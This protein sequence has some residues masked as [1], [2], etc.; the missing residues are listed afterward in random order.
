M[1]LQPKND[2]FLASH[3]L[4]KS[5]LTRWQHETLLHYLE[6]QGL[7]Q[8]VYAQHLR[9]KDDL[10]ALAVALKSHQTHTD[11]LRTCPKKKGGI[12]ELKGKKELAT[13]QLK[14]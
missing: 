12:Y 1:V 2:H 7:S 3:I 4:S 14:L 8:L 6:T 9:E 10:S 13:D 11:S 5:M